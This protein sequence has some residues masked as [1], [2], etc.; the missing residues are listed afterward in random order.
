MATAVIGRRANHV[1][2]RTEHLA[3]RGADLV[4]AVDTPGNQFTT[5]IIH[6]ERA[7]FTSRRQNEHAAIAAHR[8]GLL[9]STSIYQWIPS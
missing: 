4:I 3:G 7:Y 5:E 8:R 6:R 2:D 1:A 9:P